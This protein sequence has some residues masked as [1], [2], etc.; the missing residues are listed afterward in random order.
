MKKEGI[1]GTKI[2]Y[3][4]RIDELKNILENGK[5]ERYLKTKNPLVK[6]IGDKHDY[7]ISNRE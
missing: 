3:E 6:T 4:G 2:Q 1:P 5:K 7:F